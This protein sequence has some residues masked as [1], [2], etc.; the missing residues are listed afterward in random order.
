MISGHLK[1]SYFSE[2]LKKNFGLSFFSFQ[3]NAKNCFVI[4]HTVRLW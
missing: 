1:I 2:I 4:S 3:L